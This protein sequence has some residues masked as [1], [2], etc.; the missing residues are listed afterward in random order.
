[1][2]IAAAGFFGGNQVA[3]PPVNPPMEKE[4]IRELLGRINPESE[5]RTVLRLNKKGIE[6]VAVEIPTAEWSVEQ[7]DLY[8][9][10][11]A[12]FEE[13]VHLLRAARVDFETAYQ[14]S[15]NESNAQ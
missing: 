8:L 4:E 7:L 11:L 14:D 5:T 12:F 1:V 9:K 15:V 13:R 6:G 3:V 2:A 10:R